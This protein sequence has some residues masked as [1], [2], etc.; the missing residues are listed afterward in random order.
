MNITL[1]FLTYLIDWVRR[2]LP[3]FSTA[4]PHVA[5]YTR[6]LPVSLTRMYENAIDGE[7][8]PH[9]HKSNFASL[10]LLEHGH[11]GWRARGH[12]QPRSFM[13]EMELELRLD[14][15]KHC[16]VTTTLGGLGKGSQIITHVIPVAEDQ[17]RV[18]VDFYVPKLPKCLHAIYANQFIATYS[19]LYDEDQSMM[20][21]RQQELDRLA[22]QRSIESQ[23]KKGVSASESNQAASGTVEFTSQRTLGYWS[24]LQDQLPLTFEFNSHPYRLLQLG[25]DLLVHSTQCPHMLGPLAAAD[26]NGET[27]C[28]WH[29]YRFDV[30]TGRCLNGVS[31]HLKAA[32]DVTVDDDDRVVIS[33]A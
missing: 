24:E 13:T 18:V 32:P 6:D 19:Q 23:Q 20:V 7:H 29:G 26:T 21:A 3:N 12:L 9:L 1:S 10:E 4:L 2:L 5:N 16:W 15:D 30:R 17:I 31:C 25:K 28:P 11:W 27:E 22:E 33:I 8:L 14:R